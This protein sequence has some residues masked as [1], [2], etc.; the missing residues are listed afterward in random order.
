M[1]PAGLN[2]FAKGLASAFASE[3]RAFAAA[4]AAALL[5][6]SCKTLPPSCRSATAVWLSQSGSAPT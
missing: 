2:A 6:C 5:E 1:P 3:W 4:A